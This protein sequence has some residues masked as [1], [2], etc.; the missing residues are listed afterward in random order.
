MRSDDILQFY[1]NLHLPDS[2]LPKGVKAMN[3]Y[4]NPNPAVEQVVAEFYE[5]YYSDSKPRGLILGI[6]PGRFGAG[7]TGIPFTD[8]PALREHCHI[9]FEPETRE[10]SAEFV[11][12]VIAACGGPAVF[13]KQWFVGAAC[14]L[15]F[16]YKNERGNWVNYNYYDNAELYQA[17]KPFMISQLKAQLALCGHPQSAVVWGTGKNFQYLSKLNMEAQ[18]FEKLISLEHPRYIMQYKRRQLPH[19]L[20]KFKT[21]LGF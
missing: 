7:I 9:A 10:T 2:H 1:K 21:T 3:P 17:V 4:Q 5:R 6:N 12:R 13:Y 16:V 19:Y 11:Y 14:P 8:T 18:L 15:G 20:Q